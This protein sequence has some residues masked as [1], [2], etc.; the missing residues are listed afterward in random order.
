MLFIENVKIN[1]I[2]L[3]PNV[4]GLRE[5]EV[6]YRR[7]DEQDHAGKGPIIGIFY[8][9]HFRKWDDAPEDEERSCGGEVGLQGRVELQGEHQEDAGDR[10][11]QALVVR[12]L[13]RWPAITLWKL[14]CLQF[15][16]IIFLKMSYVA[17]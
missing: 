4:L 8:S 2:Y 15:A 3:E 6:D 10:A 7:E 9:E 17:I 1:I 13:F 11:R 14:G 16:T 12:V 5:N